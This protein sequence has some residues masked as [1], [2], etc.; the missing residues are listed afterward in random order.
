MIVLPLSPV[1]GVFGSTQTVF[2][3]VHTRNARGEGSSTTEADRALFGVIQPAGDKLVKLVPEGAQSDGAM[4][5]HTPDA[6]VA[7]AD[8]TNRNTTSTGRQTY[9]RHGGEV[10]KVWAL[11]TWTPHTNIRRFLLTKYGGGDADSPAN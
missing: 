1:L 7:A 3:R 2:D 5:L 4:V 10:W 11:Q 6:S 9:V 8:L